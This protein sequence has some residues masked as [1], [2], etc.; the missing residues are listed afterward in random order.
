MGSRIEGSAQAV[1]SRFLQIMFRVIFFAGVFPLNLSNLASQDAV[2]N[3]ANSDKQL[4]F[5]H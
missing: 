4:L 5:D 2:A 1:E 3:A